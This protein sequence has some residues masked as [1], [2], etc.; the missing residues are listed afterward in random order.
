MKG[1]FG[2]P[3][4]EAMVEVPDGV[5]CAY[6]DGA[7]KNN[8]MNAN[9]VHGGYDGMAFGGWER[10]EM[11]EGPVFGYDRDDRFRVG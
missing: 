8:L 4:G 11:N 9:Y 3:G 2:D 7:V 1:I 10:G 6:A 5:T